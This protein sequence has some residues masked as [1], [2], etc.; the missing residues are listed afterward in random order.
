[1]GCKTDPIF[2]NLTG[3][4]ALHSALLYGLDSDT[5]GFGGLR[6]WHANGQDT[7]GQA[8]LDLIGIDLGWESDRAHE[9]AEAL[10]PDVIAY[11][12]LAVV[13]VPVLVAVLLSILVAVLLTFSL[14]SAPDQ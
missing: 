1:M 4:A 12:F 8:S 2:G 7:V 5:L 14:S 9:L 10:F 13:L 11:I 6:L 3:L